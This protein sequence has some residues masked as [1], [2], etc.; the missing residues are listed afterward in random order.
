MVVWDSK[1]SPF[2]LLADDPE[3]LIRPAVDGTVGILKSITKVNPSV[4]RVVITSSVAAVLEPAEP[5]RTFTEVLPFL[6]CVLAL[7][8]SC[9]VL[10]SS[11]K[12]PSLR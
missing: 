10:I 12:P 4:K 7:P 1:A 2:H 8:D 9:S 6:R 3:E 5:P 11:S